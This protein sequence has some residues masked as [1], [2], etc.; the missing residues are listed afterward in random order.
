MNCFA[1]KYDTT[2]LKVPAWWK[3]SPGYGPDYFLHLCR[4]S[5]GERFEGYGLSFHPALPANRRAPRGL[6]NHFCGLGHLE[7]TL[8]VLSAIH[9]VTIKQGFFSFP[10]PYWPR[11]NVQ[12]DAVSL[13][14]Y[15]NHDSAR[16]DLALKAGVDGDASLLPWPVKVSQVNRE[17]AA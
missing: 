14:W 6:H 3:S 4:V 2:L 13:G 5:A 11:T 7:L 16:L 17:R 12:Q 8:A 9:G 15:W 10:A 1:C